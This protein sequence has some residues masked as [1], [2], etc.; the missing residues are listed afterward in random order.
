MIAIPLFI[1]LMNCLVL[2]KFCQKYDDMSE[3]YFGGYSVCDCFAACC[4][5]WCYKRQAY[6]AE[7]R[8][9]KKRIKENQAA[10][11]ERKKIEREALHFHGKKRNNE[12]EVQTKSGC[13]R[14]SRCLSCCCFVFGCIGSNSI[15][16]DK[17]VKHNEPVYFD[18]EE[19]NPNVLDNDMAGGESP[20][21]DPSILEDDRENI[22]FD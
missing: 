10:E 13:I 7:E 8:L 22:S 1:K 9:E 14:N 16:V 17:K 21:F 15:E 20:A 19:P 11:R 12:I 6:E 18:D 3:S 5:C 2:F 4:F